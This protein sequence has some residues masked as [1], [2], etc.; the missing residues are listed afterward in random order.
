V[1]DTRLTGTTRLDRRSGKPVLVAALEAPRIQLADFRTGE[2][3]P[4]EAGAGASAGAGG[5]LARAKPVLSHDVLNRFDRE[6]G[7]QVGELLSGDDSLGRGDLKATL[8]D[9]R[10]VLDPFD[11]D[12]PEGRVGLTLAVEPKPEQVEASLRARLDRFG[13]GILARPLDPRSRQRGLISLD[14]ELRATGPDLSTLRPGANG[15]I[16]VAP[17]PER[18]EG[19]VLELWATNVL[20]ALLRL[21]S[22][23]SQ[24]GVNCLVGA[25]DVEQG[26]LES[27]LRLVDTTSM[28]ILGSGRADFGTGA[29]RFEFRPRP[30]RREVMSLAVPVVAQ[31]TLPNVRTRVRPENP[32]RT[33]AR[34]VG[35]ALRIPLETI[36]GRRP[37]ADGR[38][39]CLAAPEAVRESAGRQG[40]PLG[41]PQLR[42]HSPLALG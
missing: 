38:P 23:F 12:L 5:K 36:L 35:N 3:S 21:V 41:A 32:L 8:Q 11:L 37:P 22:P 29:V 27:R 42:C 39:I 34:Q 31:G 6:A 10:L 40:E 7:V 19:G 33:V 26:L 17:R 18:M 30:K 2:W 1:R 9:G 28:E 16:E 4:V 15:W 20:R 13:Y 25:F 24:P 14:A